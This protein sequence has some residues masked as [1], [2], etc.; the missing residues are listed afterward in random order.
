MDKR[1]KA[2]AFGVSTFYEGH[3]HASKLFLRRAVDG[4]Q[5]LPA[6]DYQ[7][8]D[9]FITQLRIVIQDVY[10]YTHVVSIP[11]RKQGSE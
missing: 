10:S 1:Q 3:E 11:L 4:L 9:K 2:A 6:I 7:S 5:P 8:Y